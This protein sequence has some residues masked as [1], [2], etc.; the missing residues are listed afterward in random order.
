LRSDDGNTREVRAVVP[1]VSIAVAELPFTAREE[2]EKLQDAPA[3]APEQDRVT[4]PLKPLAG[5]TV[6]VLLADCPAV[7][8]PTAA[9]APTAI[10]MGEALGVSRNIAVCPVEFTIP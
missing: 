8:V 3:G 2:G 1:I 7:I 5:A 4:V 6:I 9:S 10:C